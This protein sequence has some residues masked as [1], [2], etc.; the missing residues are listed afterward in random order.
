M[1]VLCPYPVG[2]APSQRLKFEQYYDDWRAHG[3]T[4][5]VRP[6]WDE[7]GWEVLYRPGHPAEK[8]RALARGL[9]R[10]RRDVEDA[11]RADLVYLHLEAAPVGPPWI[12]RRLVK[13]RVP[14]VY[15][16]DDM[17]HLAH[18]SPANP[19]MRWVR[20]RGKIPE[21]ARIASHVIVCTPYQERWARQHNARVT[22]ISSTIDTD[23]YQPRG[24]RWE[25][26]GVVIGWSGSHSTAPYLHLLDDVLRELQ[27]D[28]AIE[29]VV[30]GEPAFSIPGA[31][32]RALPWRRESEVEDLR[33]FDV[34]V[35]PLPHDE[36]VLGK[37]GLKALQYMALGVPP[38]V[39]GIG[40]N[41]DIVRHGENGLI[42]SD[43]DEWVE[44]V[45]WLVHDPTLRERLGAEAR[46]TVEERYS[47]RATAPV[48][49]RVLDAA[50]EG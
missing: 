2:R 28:D 10:R 31:R 17:V 38:V 43:W 11:L 34:G 40:V 21:I 23:A 25:T 16:L 50:L 29:I 9:A 5:D 47:V 13:A 26:S 41:L 22:T 39:E 14:I 19:F 4:V 32:V 1:V 35:Y 3:W 46:R 12:E 20:S 7:A 18:S 6:F 42:A 36:W 45:R 24:V 8:L 30:I 49:R 44:R 48:Y 27:R 15:D 33:Q 37:S